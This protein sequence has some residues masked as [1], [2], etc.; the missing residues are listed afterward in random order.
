MSK[1]DVD[2]AAGEYVLGI[3]SPE[4]RHRFEERLEKEPALREQVARWEVLLSRLERGNQA[5]PPPDL[6]SRIERALDQQASASPFHTVRLN[7]G[8]WMPIRP[9]LE[10]KLLYRDPATG[11]ESYLFRMEPGALIEG[12][13]HARAEECLVLEGDLTIGDLHLNAGDYHVAARGSIHPVLRSQ[14]GAVMFVR[15][16]VI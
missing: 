8:E 2:I 16:A 6:W 7:D 14:G 3:L 12:H 9:G 5:A 1:F 10:R 15:G 13:H 11:T 4:Q